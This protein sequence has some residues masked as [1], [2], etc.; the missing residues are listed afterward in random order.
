MLLVREHSSIYKDPKEIKNQTQP[1]IY[2]GR[3]VYSEYEEN[4]SKPV[5]II[6]QN[7]DYDDHTE[8]EDLID[9]YLWKPSSIGKTTKSKIT[10]KNVISKKRKTTYKKPNE[11]LIL[12]W[13]CSLKSWSRIL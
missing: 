7:I 8:N 5:H 9:V 10:K 3:L 13:S 1:F 2:C 4:T 12:N 6:F 11:T